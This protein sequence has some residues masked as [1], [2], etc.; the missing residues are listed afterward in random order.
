MTQTDLVATWLSEESYPFSGWDFSHLNGRMTEPDLPWSY[1]DLAAQLMRSYDSVVD[2]GTGGGE[3]LLELGGSWPDRVF[4]TEDYEPNYQIAKAVLEP[5][6]VT[7][8][9]LELSRT[10]PMPFSDPSFGLVL[11]RHSGFNCAEVARILT[12]GGAFLTQQVHGLT[13][14]DL[15]GE[16]GATPQW[17]DAT[18]E[19]YVPRLTA[20][21]LTIDTV[22]QFRANCIF[23]DVGAIVYFLKAIPWL[24]SGFSVHDHL[25]TLLSLHQRLLRTGRLE[26]EQRYYLIRASCGG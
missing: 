9:R 12:P 10:L 3:R 7:V 2:L 26:F 23:H 24:V 15:Q 4:A 20:F 19:Y 25:P 11:N 5:L 13:L 18:P 16:F 1:I 22:Q 21:G 6:G 8:V 17:P 14:A